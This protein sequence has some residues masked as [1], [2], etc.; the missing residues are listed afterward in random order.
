M[1]VALFLGRLLYYLDD[2]FAVFDKKLETIQFGLEFNNI[3][4]DFG[5]KV[6]QLKKQI[7]YIIDF[8]GFKFDTLKIKTQLPK[9]KLVKIIRGIQNILKRKNFTIHK[10]LK[11]FISILSFMT[12]F[13]LLD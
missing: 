12:K 11:F 9:D 2:Y 5:V 3:Y 1:A 13:V 7:R 8:L 10:E 6:S 4:N